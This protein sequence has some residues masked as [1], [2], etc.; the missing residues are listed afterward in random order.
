[1]QIKREKKS[2]CLSYIL[3]GVFEKTFSSLCLNIGD[4]QSKKWKYVKQ[5]LSISRAS[6]SVYSIELGQPWDIKI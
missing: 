5:T 1:V 2:Y 4:W 6:D 3:V